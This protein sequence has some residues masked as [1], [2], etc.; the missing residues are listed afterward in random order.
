MVNTKIDLINRLTEN[1][2]MR[3]TI[4]YTLMLKQKSITSNITINNVIKY[5]IS[6]VINAVKILQTEI[7]CP[8]AIHE[9]K[10]YRDVNKD[11][12]HPQ[13]FAKGQ[14][15]EK[16]NSKGSLPSV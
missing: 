8:S 4:K 15:R 2:T 10:D 12:T 9:I 6:R 1:V 5:M 14:H 16:K 3:N 11:T 7:K 13:P